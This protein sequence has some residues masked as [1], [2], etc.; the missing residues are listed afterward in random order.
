VRVR[1]APGPEQLR[2]LERS[3]PGAP[4][5]WSECRVG[6]ALVDFDGEDGASLRYAILNLGAP[7]RSALDARLAALEAAL[8]FEFEPVPEP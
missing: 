2:A 7:D 5:L 1:A 4:L 6:E 3:F 8:G